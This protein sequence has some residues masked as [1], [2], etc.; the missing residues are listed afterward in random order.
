MNPG[1]VIL[2]SPPGIDLRVAHRII[3]IGS[4]GL[5]TRGDNNDCIDPWTLRTGDV[6]GR[7]VEAKRGY[8]RLKVH[9]G[10]MGLSICAL[11]RFRRSVIKR[12]CSFI[13]VIRPAYYWLSGSSL[14]GRWLSVWPL[15][16]WLKPKLLSFNRSEGIELQLKLGGRVIGRRPPGKEWRITPPFRMLVDEKELPSDRL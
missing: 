10:R 5:S 4:N 12:T 6:I 11:L 15:S 1:D 2:F 8:R 16:A 13:P 3:S 9:G 14:L 7:V